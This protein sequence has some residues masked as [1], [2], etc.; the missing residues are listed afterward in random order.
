MPRY[1]GRAGLNGAI[2][3]EVV[4]ALERLVAN[5]NYLQATRQRFG[6]EP[7]PYHSSTEEDEDVPPP[8]Y[9][10]I[11]AG[12]TLPKDITDIIDQPLDEKAK[13]EK[14]ASTL[15][16]HHEIKSW[17]N[18]Y[19]EGQWRRKI[20]AR[21][22][23]KRRWQK[24]GVW[25]PQWGIPGRFKPRAGDFPEY[26]KWKW[27]GDDTVY[28][29]WKDEPVS[30]AVFLR[31]GLRRGEQ[32][33]LPPRSHITES[34][35]VS[36]AESFIT[37]RPW[38]VFRLDIHEEIARQATLPRAL[39]RDYSAPRVGWKWRHESP[40][41]EPEDLAQYNGIDDFDLTPSEID[42]METIPPPTPP[43][44]PVYLRPTKS[45]SP[46]APGSLFGPPLHRSSYPVTPL[47]VLAMSKETED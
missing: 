30:R 19:Y 23:V 24:L 16:C 43:R 14:F 5:P 2:N 15:E 11:P 1:L 34:T 35:S 26:W 9:Q 8:M 31:H 4:P 25:N 18:E 39:W 17:L 38:F 13:I 37:S 42:A 46:P 21:H 40:S 6:D 29:D 44:S 41:P 10:K 47:A 22:F 20:L 7:P 3:T 32:G 12:S 27:Q 45:M 36:Q 33:P 28:Q